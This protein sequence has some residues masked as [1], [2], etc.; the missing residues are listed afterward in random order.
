[1]TI[2]LN[3]VRLFVFKVDESH[4]RASILDTENKNAHV[5]S[6]DEIIDKPYYNDIK[7][8]LTIE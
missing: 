8:F 5:Y 4:F 7:T 3:G 1:M 6:L 2:D